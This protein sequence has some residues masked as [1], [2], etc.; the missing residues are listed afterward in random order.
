MID[1][2]PAL[3]ERIARLAGGDGVH[4]TPIKLLHLI[5]SARPT[6]HIHTV[7]APAICIVAQGAKRVM[8][9]ERV[10]DYDAAHHLVVSFDL[11]IVGQITQ[12]DPAFPYLCL[13]LDFDA[14][15]LAELASD[16]EWDQGRV[17]DA[18]GLT[19]GRTSHDILDAA[20]RLLRLAE[21]PADIPVLA[22]LYKRELLYRVVG[23]P[24]GRA[25]LRAVLGSGP[26]RQVA[27]AIAWIKETYREPFEMVR[28]SEA[29]RMQP[30]AL[31]HHFKAFTLTSPLQYQK[32]LRLLEARRLMLFEDR[33][34]AEAAFAVGY[35][36]PSQFSREY[37]RQFGKPPRRDVVDFGDRTMAAEPP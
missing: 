1:P 27:R 18:P 34:A 23:A 3:A 14:G 11:P 26:G 8:L 32:R 7:H 28:L 33:S 15:A 36:S 21:T 22:P 6:Q 12:A 37:R 9:G 29:A 13:R 30:S 16:M 35:E 24:G 17:P 19:L 2:L 4:R 25:A 5:R 20:D 10:Y 31:H